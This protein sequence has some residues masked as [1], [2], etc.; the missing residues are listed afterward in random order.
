ML[1]FSLGPL[2]LSL[3]HLLLLMA[4]ALSTLVGWLAGRR[5]RINPERA[6][7]AL[8]LLGLL[9]ARLAFVAAYWPQYQSQILRIVDIR[10]GG[11]LIWPGVVAVVVATTVLVWNRPLQRK[12]LGL[13]VA[14]GLLFWWLAGLVVSAQHQ[15]VSL[16]DLTL[17]DTAG[18]PVQLSDYAGRKLVI[19]LWATWC[20][21]CRREMP[22]LQAAQRLNPDV[23]FLFV[24]QAESPRE[25]ATFLASQGL[26]LDN[27]LFDD[28]GELARSV[29]SAA[30]PTTLF[31]NPDAS[32]SGSHL[33]ELSD[34]SLKH[35][36]DNLSAPVMP[37]SSQPRSSQ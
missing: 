2:V 36:L 10:D 1:S 29:G 11:F 32:L 30:L 19:N 23:V 22:V 33:G 37:S 24:N 9:V 26:H 21:P 6:L 15:N 28:S 8:F 27:V 5:R 20:P 7:F 13:G 18:R 25:V 16:P 35:Y 34:A 4:L 14:S 31:Y 3:T 12:A 17:R